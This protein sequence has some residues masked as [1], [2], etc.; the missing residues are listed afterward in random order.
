MKRTTIF[1]IL[2]LIFL[3]PLAAHSQKVTVDWDHGIHNFSVFRTYSWVRPIRPVANQLMDRRIVAAI[4][5]QLSAKGLKKVDGKADLL[6]TYGTGMRRERSATAMG[7]GMGRFRMG[8]GMAT[9]NRNVS[10]V[11]MLTVDITG[12]KSNLLIWR[13]TAADT[14]SNKPEKNTKKIDKAVAK[15]F[16]KYPPPMK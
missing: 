11:G 5:N 15:M 4:E 16:K 2:A 13:G 9:I 14:L 12:A 1:S 10:T 8:G 7:M 6:V 3:L